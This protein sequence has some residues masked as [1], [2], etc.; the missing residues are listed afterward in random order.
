MRGELLFHTSN[1]TRVQQ[2]LIGILQVLFPPVQLT[3]NLG[4]LMYGFTQECMNAWIH[5]EM[6]GCMDR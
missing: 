1:V 4:A 3:Q 6:H 5:A 2:L